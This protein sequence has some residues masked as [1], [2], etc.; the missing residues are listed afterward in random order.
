[1]VGG[2]DTRGELRD[3]WCEGQGHS[4]A[5]S[6]REAAMHATCMRKVVARV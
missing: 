4:G 6:V 1:M 2:G 5:G 3:G